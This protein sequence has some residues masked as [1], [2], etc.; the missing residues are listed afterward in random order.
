MSVTD[1]QKDKA[2]SKAS[3]SDEISQAYDV[4]ANS[5]VQAKETKVTGVIFVSYL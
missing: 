5:W 1:T 3:F 4:I 2:V